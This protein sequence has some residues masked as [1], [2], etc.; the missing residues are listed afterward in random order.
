MSEETAAPAEGGTPEGTPTD[1]GSGGKASM[2]SDPTPAEGGEGGDAGSDGAIDLKSLLGDELSADQNIAKFLETDNPVQEL[3]KSLVES[4]KQMG[5]KM[6]I[7]TEESTPE[8]AAAFY[9]ELG[10]P[11]KGTAEDYGFTKPEGM[12]DADFN[13]E[14]AEKWAGLMKEHN[15]PKEAAEALRQELFAEGDAHQEAAL[16]TL[17]EA[18]DKSFGENKAAISKEVGDMLTEAVPDAE[19]RATIEASLGDEKTPAFALALGHVMQHMKKTY[20][21]AD[22]NAGDDSQLSGKTVEELRAEAQKEMTSDAYRDPMHRDH[23]TKKA[24]VQGMYKE[25]G[26]LTDQANKG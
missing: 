13:A 8:E 2:L 16:K 19:L 21:L 7:P 22:K 26:I 9:K 12:D 17:N 23:K 3:A 24:E 6:G 11:E 25:I 18:L 10:V 5:K 15:V 20:G 1:D 14:H 4:Q